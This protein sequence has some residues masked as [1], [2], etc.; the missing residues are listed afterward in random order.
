MDGTVIEL[1]WT[2][3]FLGGHAG[4]YK[5]S[6]VQ[7]VLSPTRTITG[8]SLKILERL[9]RSGVP[10]KEEKFQFQQTRP[11]RFEISLEWN[12]TVNNPEQELSIKLESG[13]PNESRLLLR[14]PI[15]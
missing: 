7:V 9:L 5:A 8:A 15:F 11:G 2:Y 4:L 13:D 1:D 6:P 14:D 12:S 3:Y 10:T